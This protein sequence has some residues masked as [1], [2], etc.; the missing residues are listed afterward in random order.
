[1]IEVR[2]YA[3]FRADFPD[4]CIWNA[5]E[6]DVVQ[7]GGK[8]VAEAI[9]DILSSFG[10]VIEE[11]E[12]HVGHS[13]DCRFSYEGLVLW[14]HVVGWGDYIFI[15]EEPPRARP[16]YALH[17]HL[18]LKLNEAMRRDGRFHDLRWYEDERPRRE[19]FD[20]PVVG[21][22]PTVDEIKPWE[23]AGVEGVKKRSFL[24]ML[25]A[26]LKARPEDR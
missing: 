17:L 11:L 8:A 13:W 25:L 7:T 20:V 14:F 4:D 6:T 24:D 3:E 1:M 2:R 19:G 26:P 10:C 12:D 16:D 21:D 23:R 9:A 15:L 5:D 18:L 22:V